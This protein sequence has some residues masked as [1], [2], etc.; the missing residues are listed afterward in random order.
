VL[1]EIRQELCNRIEVL[2]I[3]T[4]PHPSQAPKA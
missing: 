2:G 1:D 4:M 3:V